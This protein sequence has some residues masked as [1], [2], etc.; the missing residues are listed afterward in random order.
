MIKVNGGDAE[1]SSYLFPTHL[2]D[3]LHE[4]NSDKV[5]RFAMNEY[6]YTAKPD[7]QNVVATADDLYIYACSIIFI[8]HLLDKLQEENADKVVSFAMDE[9]T[10][11]VKT[12]SSKCG[13]HRR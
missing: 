9:Y 1:E 6:T 8:T 11:T 3:K 10:N 2:L 12:I 13:R 7:L 4:E 5:V